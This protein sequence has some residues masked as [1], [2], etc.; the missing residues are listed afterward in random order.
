MKFKKKQFIAKHRKRCL[1]GTRN[2]EFTIQLP[3]KYIKS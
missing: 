2:V 3:N 1:D